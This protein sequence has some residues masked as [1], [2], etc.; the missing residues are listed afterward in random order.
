MQKRIH[1]LLQADKLFKVVALFATFSLLFL[2]LKPPGEDSQ[3]WDILF[4]R[5]DLVLHFIGY[6]GLTLLYFFAFYT[7][8]NTLLKAYVYAML[9]GVCTE[10]LQ[11]ISI[12]Q[13]H[14]DFVDLI[15]NLFGGFCAWLISKRFFY[16]SIDN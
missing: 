7:H 11:L 12:F 14:F 15:A 9:I 6:F 8:T 10:I 2:S 3:P 16:Y 1:Q 5:A 13:R 4:I